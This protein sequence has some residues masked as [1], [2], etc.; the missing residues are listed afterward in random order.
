MVAQA[1]P[2]AS[3]AEDDELVVVA[4]G[5]VERRGERYRTSPP[6]DLACEEQRSAPPR[7]SARAQTH[8]FLFSS[9]FTTKRTVR[10]GSSSRR[11]GVPPRDTGPEMAHDA[12]FK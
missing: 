3:R 6:S 11:A 1:Q 8:A 5:S 2:G 10:I 7:I 12:S 4:H 9:S